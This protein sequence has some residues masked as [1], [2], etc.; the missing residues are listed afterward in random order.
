MSKKNQRYINLN[1]KFPFAQK[2]YFI[3]FIIGKDQRLTQINIENN[4]RIYS[5]LRSS[6]ILT[7]IIAFLILSGAV[8][9]LAILYLLKMWAGID[10]LQGSSP[11]PELLRTLQLCHQFYFINFLHNKKSSLLPLCKRELQNFYEFPI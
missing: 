6:F 5:S 9:F 3:S 11:I 10:L 2:T 4:Q 1:L 7:V 8:C